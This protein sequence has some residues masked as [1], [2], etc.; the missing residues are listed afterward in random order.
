MSDR[1]SLVEFFTII[2]GGLSLMGLFGIWLETAV[3][4]QQIHAGE[5]V[6]EVMEE[7]EE[8]ACAVAESRRTHR[9]RGTMTEVMTVYITYQ[10]FFRLPV[11]VAV[12]LEDA[13]M[14]FGGGSVDSECG[15]ISSR[16]RVAYCEMI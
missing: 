5:E 11:R 12:S 14:C 9:V 1:E 7:V 3:M 16:S 8:E 15:V 2:L 13:S 6:R 4:A 10:W